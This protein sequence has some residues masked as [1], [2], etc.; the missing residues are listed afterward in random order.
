MNQ[1]KESLTDV[2]LSSHRPGK[3]NTGVESYVRFFIL[4]P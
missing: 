4:A 2:N 3:Q 1:T